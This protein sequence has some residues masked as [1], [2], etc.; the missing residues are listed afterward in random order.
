[1]PSGLFAGD[2]WRV[3]E[4]GLD[5]SGLRHRVIANNIANADTPQFKSSEVEF[6]TELR[7]A[8]EGTSP[9]G[10]FPYQRKIDYPAGSGLSSVAP[11]VVERQG[12]TAR[13][14]GNNVDV[15]YEMTAM[16][17]NDLYYQALSRLLNDGFTR[18]RTAIREGR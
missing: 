3:L 18:L 13:N 11:Q 14:D 9:R 8:L 2:S 12:L 5:A 15:D 1:M 7:R 17:E 10:V 16:A 6:E 4:K